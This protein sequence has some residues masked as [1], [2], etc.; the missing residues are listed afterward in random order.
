MNAKTEIEWRWGVIAAIA[1]TVLALYP[2]LHFRVLNGAAETYVHVE[3]VGDEVAYSAYVNALIAG[4]PRRNDPYTG[5]DDAPDKPQPESLF[6][7]Q[8]VPA[9]MVALP[10]RV[11]G[12]SANA[13]FIW[14][15][16]MSACAS[17]LAVFWL[18]ANITRQDQLAAVGAV[19]ILCLG[20]L[21]SG[22]GQIVALFGLKPLYNYL[23]FLRRYQP[24]ATF[25]FF[26][27]FC[28]LVWR[29]LNRTSNRA[30]LVQSLAAGAIFCLLVF[31]YFY[32]WTAAAA[33]LACLALLWLWAR[34][35]GW[36]GDLKYFAVTGA[37][38][39]TA[40][41]PYAFLLSHRAATMDTVN[42]YTVSR[43]LD[44]FRLPELVA[45]AVLLTLGAMARRGVIDLREKAV[46]FAASFALMPLAVFNQQLITGRTMQSVHYE[47][48]IANYSVLLAIVLSAAIIHR[49]RAG[50]AVRFPKKALVWI[51]LAAFEWGAYEAF[52]AANGSVELNKR[53]AAAGP[54]AQRLAEIARTGEPRL[55]HSTILATDLLIAD[56]LPTSAPQALLYAP[57]M[58]VYPGAGERESR[59]RFYQYLYYTGIDESALKRILTEEGRYGFVS[60]L[61]GF[62]RAV[63]GLKDE[64]QPITRDELD[65]ELRRYA[66]YRAS[67]TRERAALLPLSYLV[68]ANDAEVNL[69]N[70]D[71][72]YER[73]AGE[74]LGSF[75]L[76]G[77]KLKDER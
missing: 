62:E 10:A 1:L 61:F 48:F 71:Q 34:P 21:I 25:P 73:D 40:L 32:L 66:E 43:R 18:I 24:S 63:D 42:A 54:I 53:L 77:L 36:R 19:F 9:Y 11:L 6:S 65:Q 8:F 45:V 46:L 5:R 44:L 58:L 12:I 31:S 3:G 16:L 60:A 56:S 28:A 75:T 20:T 26:F 67:F 59:E 2:Q 47:M 72:W 33:W 64:P 23:I 4:R 51:A 55:A 41:L 74:H 68:L 29:M 37:L 15:M 30:S 22:H 57:H 35:D 7:V 69:S 14:L 39:V 13:S 27:I 70:L 17:T 50:T 76:Y 38:A 52:V 49:G